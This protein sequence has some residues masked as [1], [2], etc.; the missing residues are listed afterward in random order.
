MTVISRRPS[1]PIAT[2]STNSA[3]VGATVATAG[4]IAAGP[5]TAV[6]AAAALNDTMS[7][8]PLRQAFVASSARSA[9][10]VSARVEP[11][12]IGA[13]TARWDMIDGATRR[14]D[15][16]YFTVDNDAFGMA[17]VGHLLKKQRAGVPV[18]LMFDG[19]ADAP[20]KSFK[21]WSRECLNQLVRDGGQVRVYNA[22]HTRVPH[23]GSAAGYAQ[24]HDK[25]LI[26]D[27]ERGITG[28]RN[29]G[30]A[31]FSDPT[32]VPTA[33]RDTDVAL[34][35][36]GAAQGLL[37][38]ID[39]EWNGAGT[40]A[41][42]NGLW[43]ESKEV[44][45]IG[46]YL[47][48]DLWM[49]E[50]PLSPAKKSAVRSSEKARDRVAQS[51]V[52]RAIARL[53]TEGVS[54]T[55]DTYE[56]VTLDEL[57]KQLVNNLELCGSHGRA[58]AMPTRHGVHAH[59]I[60]RTSARVA[61]HDDFG[62]ALIAT[63]DHAQT[64]LLIQNPYVVL[65]RQMLEALERAA[66]RGVQITIVTNSPKSTD[67][68]L[69]QTFFLRDWPEVLARLPGSKLFVFG[70]ERKMHAKV[71]VADENVS[72]VS[73]YNLDLLSSQIN[74]EVGSLMWSKEVASDVIKSID[75]DLNDPRNAV[76]EYTIQR[77]VDGRAMRID[78]KPIVVRGPGSHV[79]A[80]TVRNYRWAGDVA[81]I[82]RRVIPGLNDMNHDRD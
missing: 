50:P 30:G 73:T 33:W 61:A 6:P 32:D 17:F 25:I 11:D 1:T 49:K 56:M 15:T 10:S 26:V 59:I 51:L 58:T 29:I 80:D 66:N 75:D 42:G 28:G 63:A 7:T 71:A 69:T 81:D 52:E 31:Y 27:G 78:G 45:L 62:Q 20:G 46:A 70:G 38:A 8:D 24:N 48:M 19:M 74:G 4:P 2:V 34:D 68:A 77:D 54:R 79:D 9:S 57:A 37:E 22:V 18:R 5:T 41:V 76:V 12:N 35:G 53:P 47:L 55:P 72:L 65:T 40:A 64:R 82:A 39:A 21:L 67:S 23:L 16:T 60:D 43:K 13:W 44:E 3:P 36:I 14:I